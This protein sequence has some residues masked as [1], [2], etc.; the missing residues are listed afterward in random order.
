M[1]ESD[2]GSKPRAASLST[3]G[4]PRLN[5]MRLFGNANKKEKEKTS[6]QVDSNYSPFVQDDEFE[7]N[8][9]S[10]IERKHQAKS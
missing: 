10:A 5:S 1:Q 2:P 9:P 3:W 6:E 7:I 8:A 4:L